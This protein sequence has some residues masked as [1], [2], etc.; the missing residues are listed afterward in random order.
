[1]TAREWEVLRLVAAGRSNN[2][3]AEELVLSVRTVE[4]HLAHVY[5]KLGVASRVE[6]ALFALKVSAGDRLR[7]E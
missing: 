2:E 7:H 6:A 3:V 1:L 4:N 5:S